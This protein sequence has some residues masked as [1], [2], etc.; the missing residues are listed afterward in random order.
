MIVAWEF[1]TSFHHRLGLKRSGWARQLAVS[2]A[3]VAVTTW[4]F[5][6]KRGSG[7][8]KRSPP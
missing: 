6:W 7:L 5:M 1:S 4:A 2:M 8:R 3:Q